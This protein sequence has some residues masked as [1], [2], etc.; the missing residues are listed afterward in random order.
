MAQQTKSSWMNKLNESDLS[1]IHAVDRTTSL[2]FKHSTL[3]LCHSAPTKGK[4]Y[5]SMLI[6]QFLIYSFLEWQKTLKANKELTNRY[7]RE[8]Q[9]AAD[10]KERVL[11]YQSRFTNLMVENNQNR[12]AAERLEVENNRLRRQNDGMKSVLEAA[13]NNFT[14]F[15]DVSQLSGP[16]LNEPQH[17]T[18]DETIPPSNASSALLTDELDSRRT[19]MFS[20]MDGSDFAETTVNLPDSNANTLAL[21]ES[22][23][24]ISE[25]PESESDDETIALNLRKSMA[26]VGQTKLSRKSSRKTMRKT[27][28][29]RSRQ[30]EV[31]DK[32]KSEVQPRRISRRL[33]Q[34]KQ[35]PDIDENNTD[36]TSRKCT[37]INQ[38][39]FNDGTQTD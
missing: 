18:L 30:S 22:S 3:P 20:G 21:D 13:V 8:K 6:S 7:R 28:Q 1:F 9:N 2:S 12:H 37:L 16:S 32:R 31:V 14:Q 27:I 35:K 5:D 39:K 11:E 23:D 15:V 17:I 26:V 36:Q 38:L 34:Q 25:D 29:K 4:S 10:L 33:T 24:Q 19:S